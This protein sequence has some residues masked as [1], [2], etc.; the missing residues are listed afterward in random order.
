MIIWDEIMRMAVEKWVEIRKLV[1]IVK[2]LL[3]ASRE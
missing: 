1:E 2:R 3:S